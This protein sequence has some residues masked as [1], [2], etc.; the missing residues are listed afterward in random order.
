MLTR[1]ILILYSFNMILFDQSYMILA[2]REWHATLVVECLLFC[3]VLL[4]KPGIVYM[5]T[6][7]SSVYASIGLDVS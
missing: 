5:S 2:D 7:A 3:M 6:K 4:H 1:L